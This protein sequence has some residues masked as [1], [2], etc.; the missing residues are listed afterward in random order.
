MPDEVAHGCVVMLGDA[1]P[2]PLTAHC[3]VVGVERL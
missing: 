1:P 3:D 2:A